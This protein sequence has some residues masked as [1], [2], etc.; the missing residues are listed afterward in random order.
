M[1]KDHSDSETGNLLPPHG[2]HF[3]I[4]SSDLLYASSHRQDSTSQPLL[5]RK[6]MFLFNDTLNTFNLQLYG[7]GSMVKNHSDGG[8]GNLLPPHGLLL[9]I[10]S[11]GYFICTIPQTV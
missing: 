6:E 5:G 8:S 9:P 3:S 1:V 11:K 7:I 10:T 2:L 4:S